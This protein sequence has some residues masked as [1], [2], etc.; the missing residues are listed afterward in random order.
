MMNDIIKQ[1]A[2]FC[3]G[4]VRGLVILACLLM[5]L[6]FVL[7]VFVIHAR[8]ELISEVGEGWDYW[9]NLVGF[10]TFTYCTY[11]AGKSEGKKVIEK[12]SR[13]SN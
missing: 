11:L 6:Y 4:V 3:F 2:Y 1:V 5:A 10:L 12:L 8:S 7:N 9:F 13:N